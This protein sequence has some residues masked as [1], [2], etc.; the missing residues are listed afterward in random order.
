M[1]ELER[2]ALL[3][4]A[5]ALVK[6]AQRALAQQDALIHQLGDE[7]R[8]LETVLPLKR[9]QL[10]RVLLPCDWGWRCDDCGL[11]VPRWTP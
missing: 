7:I 8:T 11:P 1:S 4:A 6:D 5:S 10:D 3:E 2:R 9:T